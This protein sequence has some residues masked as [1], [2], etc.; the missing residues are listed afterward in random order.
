MIVAALALAGIFIGLY[1]TLY[2]LGIIGELTCS[3]GSCETVNTSKWAVFL[4]FPVA[5]WGVFF[6]VAVFVLALVGTSERL[7]DARMISVLL[8][9]WSTVGLLFSAWLTYLELA[10]I[11]A[12]CIWCVVSAILV[13]AIF[14][15]SVLDLRDKSRMPATD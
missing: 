4:G 5:A 8:S 12:I 14:A 6:Y 7:A 3:V 15:L 10:V 2:K 11:Q 1:L 9:L 13:T